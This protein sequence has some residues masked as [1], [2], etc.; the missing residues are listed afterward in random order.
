MGN[1]QRIFDAL[2]ELA[3][4]VNAVTS[5]AMA[6][7]DGST[8]TFDTGGGYTEGK[9]VVEIE[10]IAEVIRATASQGISIQLRGSATKAFTSEVVLAQV[11]LG[12]AGGHN[13]GCRPSTATCGTPTTNSRFIVPFCNDW[14]GTVYRY[15]R[16]YHAFDGTVTTGVSYI[17]YLTKD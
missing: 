8:V 11:D 15:L 3:K 17:A 10:S 4:T 7:V 13:V 5:S 2:C 1:R 16:C 9:F 14:N 6:T 12:Y